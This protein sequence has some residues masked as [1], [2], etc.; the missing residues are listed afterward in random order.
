[1]ISY[2]LHSLFGSRNW[3]EGVDLSG[4]PRRINREKLDYKKIE[5]D[6][7]EPDSLRSKVFSGYE[8]LLKK[9]CSQNAFDPLGDQW[10]LDLHSSLFS[11]L[12]ISPDN[13]QRVLCIQNLSPSNLQV[14]ID[15]VE[16]FSSSS[17]TVLNIL[18]GE[19][20]KSNGTLE[21]TVNPYEI[22]WLCVNLSETI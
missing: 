7:S 17:V 11:I 21:L 15:P 4:K 8:L 5:E 20:I 12:R 1:V 18:T 16:I 22:A 14:N 9:R 13:R 3:Q 10:V 6:L 19:E 2:F